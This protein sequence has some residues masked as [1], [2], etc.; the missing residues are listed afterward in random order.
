L[1]FQT[2]ELQKSIPDREGEKVDQI[3]T[4][5]NQI[6]KNP[7]QACNYKMDGS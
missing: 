3:S 1:I 7:D 2:E 5:P 6:P 4:V